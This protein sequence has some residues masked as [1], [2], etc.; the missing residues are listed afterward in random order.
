MARGERAWSIKTDIQRTGTLLLLASDGSRGPVS[1]RRREELDARHR[2]SIWAISVLLPYE[3]RRFTKSRG[4]IRRFRVKRN[5]DKTY[6]CRHSR[7]RIQSRDLVLYN[8]LW[9][10]DL[11]C[12][13]ACRGLISLTASLWPTKRPSA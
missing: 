2:S 4:D 13:Y 5:R 1:A 10:L 7:R 9:F 12:S 8:S 11:D 6:I 3:L